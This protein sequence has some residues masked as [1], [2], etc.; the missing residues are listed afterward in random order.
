LYPNVLDK[1]EED[2]MDLLIKGGPILWI[3]IGLSFLAIA[4]IIERILYLKRI[5]VDEEKLFNRVKSAWKRVTLMKPSS[6]VKVIFPP[7]RVL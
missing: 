7:L 2:L 4:I 1:N 3:I 6:C 5:K